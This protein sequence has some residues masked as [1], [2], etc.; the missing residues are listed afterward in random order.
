MFVSTNFL[1]HETYT[2]KYLIG[3]TPSGFS[4]SVAETIVWIVLLLSYT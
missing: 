1:I 3:T 4:Y 2:L